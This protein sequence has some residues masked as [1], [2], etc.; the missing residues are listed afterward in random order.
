M[1]CR[2][3]SGSAR[4]GY[5]A[6]RH[7]MA[8]L[9]RA[10]C[11]VMGARWR[12]SVERTSFLRGEV[13]RLR[14]GRVLKAVVICRRKSGNPL[15][16]VEDVLSGITPP[17]PGDHRNMRREL[18]VISR[19][20]KRIQACY[21]EPPKTPPPCR[22]AHPPD[23]QQPA[24]ASACATTKPTASGPEHV[25]SERLTGRVELQRQFLALRRAG[26]LPL[27]ASLERRSL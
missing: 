5:L 3:C 27:Q 10:R 11:S 17:W 8:C 23:T 13:V 2:F 7:V 6:K 19:E 20:S 21:P 14:L 24:A 1:Y 26:A 25:H 22:S 9:L 16:G 15:D 18:I 12:E 4:L